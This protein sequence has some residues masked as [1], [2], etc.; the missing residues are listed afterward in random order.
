[1]ILLL[2]VTGEAPCS[3]CESPHVRVVDRR[4]FPTVLEPVDHPG[5]KDDLRD[6]A[7]IEPS[8]SSALL[9]SLDQPQRLG[10][11]LQAIGLPLSRHLARGRPAAL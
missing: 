1:L 10:C 2:D 9:S 11:R 8:E 6:P 4:R 3:Y 7:R 5:L